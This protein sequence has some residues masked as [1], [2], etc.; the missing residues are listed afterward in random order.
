M[1]IPLR[2]LA[3]WDTAADAWEVE[4][5]EFE[6]SVGRSSRDLPLSVTVTISPGTGIPDGRR[7]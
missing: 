1:A 3:H 7:C 6:L 4:P 2:R 5:G